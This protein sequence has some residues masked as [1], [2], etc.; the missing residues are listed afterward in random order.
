VLALTCLSLPVQTLRYG[1]IFAVESSIDKAYLDTSRQ[2]LNILKKKF[3]LMEH[4]KAFKRYLLLSQGDF[5]QYLLDTLGQ[6]S[7][8]LFIVWQFT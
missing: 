4:L 1:N 3:K 8:Q 5:I 2:L 6:V 7:A